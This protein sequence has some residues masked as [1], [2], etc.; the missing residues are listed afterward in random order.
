[1]HCGPGSDISASK[2]SFTV[3]LVPS[4]K[5]DGEG[6]EC[7]PFDTCSPTAREAKKGHQIYEINRLH[8]SLKYAKDG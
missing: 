4:S 1:M 5:G 2:K 8:L 6:D 3:T 7:E